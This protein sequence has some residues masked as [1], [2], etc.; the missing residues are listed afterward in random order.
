[1]KPTN[2]H[3]RLGGDVFEKYAPH[4]D[5]Y[6]GHV[7]VIDHYHSYMYPEEECK[8]HVW[9]RCVDMPELK[10]GGYIELD[11][12][13]PVIFL[14]THSHHFSPNQ[15]YIFKSFQCY[16][17]AQE[18]RKQK[19]EEYVEKSSDE[20]TLI[21]EAQEWYESTIKVIDVDYKGSNEVYRENKAVFAID[22]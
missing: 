16:D 15:K 7:F 8:D 22:E 21:E 14:V 3:Y 13:V 5:S 10:M 2:Q 6:R 11:N 19:I 1:M 4:Y 17:E 9:L 20:F 18:Y 12:L